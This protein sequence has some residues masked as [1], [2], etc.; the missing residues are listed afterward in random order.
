MAHYFET[1]E[2]KEIL[3]RYEHARSMGKPG[4]FD[5]REYIDL[6]DYY[7]DA[8]DTDHGLRLLNEGLK[9][10]PDDKALTAAK[11]GLLIDL[12]RYKQ[13][14]QLLSTLGENDDRD[15]LF[16]NAQLTLAMDH[17]A[18][19]AERMFNEW[20]D[21]VRRL[22]DEE[23]ADD[24]CG[25]EDAEDYLRSCHFHVA[26]AFA[27][28]DPVGSM[29]Y[30]Y[31]WARRYL[32]TYE[33]LGNY[34]ADGF[35]AELCRD[36]EF[37]DLLEEV[38]TRALHNNPYM[39]DG[40]QQLAAAQMAN[41]HY[42]EAI[43]SAEFALAVNPDD[44]IALRAQADAHFQLRHMDQALPL[45]LRYGQSGMDMLEPLEA[46]LVAL[47][48]AM[49]LV[50]N[51]QQQEA[52]PHVDKAIRYIS[53][54]RCGPKHPEA[55]VYAW[56][57]Y[58][59]AL[60]CNVCGLY[61][62]ALKMV[63]KAIHC[64]P[65]NIDCQ[66]LKCC[67]ELAQDDNKSL[68]TVMQRALTHASSIAYT[69]STLGGHLFSLSMHAEARMCLEFLLALDAKGFFER[70]PQDE[71]IEVYGDPVVDFTRVKAFLALVCFSLGDV[72]AMLGYAEQACKEDPE[73]LVPLFNDIVPDT[74]L[75]QDYYQYLSLH[76][77]TP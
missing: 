23:L 40:W 68:E 13:A 57:A 59:I 26:S 47:N 31:R 61:A 39:E 49:C 22:T 1:P 66:V 53:A 8:G 10:Y 52:I 4:F 62:K 28:I 50:T 3:H 60:I 33:E 7:V 27:N 45:Y 14:R 71:D 73:A 25:E 30:A 55:V 76:R 37:V 41:E 42:E 5:A 38:L 9:R 12:C 65:H 74:V 67:L 2:F 11:V 54:M 72:D 19:A 6:S 51:N 21:L 46:S 32:D 29:D 34:E 15:Y 24:A 20:I 44:R 43:E 16:L 64:A 75:P 18:E 69:L 63:N 17:D 56:R 77:P 58:H 35:L 48:T 70:Y 36:M